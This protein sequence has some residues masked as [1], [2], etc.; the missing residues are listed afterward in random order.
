[1]APSKQTSVIVGLKTTLHREFKN[2][3]GQPSAHGITIILIA[4]F[5]FILIN[6]FMGLFPYIFTSSSHITLTLGLALPL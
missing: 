4:L 6:N 5:T 2:L 3:L 1:V